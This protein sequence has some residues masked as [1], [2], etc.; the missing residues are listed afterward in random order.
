[1]SFAAAG[2]SLDSL[3]TNTFL[4]AIVFCYYETLLCLGDKAKFQEELTRIRSLS[5][6]LQA[7][8]HGR[9]I[10]EDW[11]DETL[12][13]LKTLS[14]CSL[15]R[16]NAEIMAA[17]NEGGTWM[18]IITYFKVRHSAHCTYLTQEAYSR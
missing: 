5:N 4:T 12:G 14:S 3:P 10:Y 17:F 13:L 15:D 16:G 1:M 9:D 2:C 6:L 8:G 7:V 11:E 18:A